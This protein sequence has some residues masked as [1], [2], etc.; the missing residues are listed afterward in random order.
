M[1]APAE[2]TEESAKGKRKA[3]NVI[4][5]KYCILV[6][7]DVE[8][9]RELA[10]DILN[11]AGCEVLAVSNGRAGVEVCHERWREIGIVILDT[12]LQAT[13]CWDAY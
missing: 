7:G 4:K 12:I 10:Q 3:A 13:G 11:E 1:I 5:K 2:Q 8:L 9:L 6:V